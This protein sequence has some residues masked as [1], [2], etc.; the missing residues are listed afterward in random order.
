MATMLKLAA[1]NSINQPK[2]SNFYDPGKPNPVY[3]ALD[4]ETNDFVE[5]IKKR[6]NSK[7]PVC[8]V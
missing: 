3:K 8:R 5:A 4:Q 1:I 7:D 6:Y 2:S